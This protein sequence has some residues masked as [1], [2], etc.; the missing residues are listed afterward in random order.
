LYNLKQQTMDTELENKMI[1]LLK[2]LET[3]PL[4]EY[5]FN[6]DDEILNGVLNE[7]ETRL[8]TVEYVAFCNELYAA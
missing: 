3:E 2:Q 8:D 7:L 1:D 4:K 5:A 6:C